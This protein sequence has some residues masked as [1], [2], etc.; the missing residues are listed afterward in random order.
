MDV[1]KAS[2]ARM[3]DYLLGGTDNYESDWAA[4]EELLRIAP[5]TQQIA[6]TNRRFLER[7]VKYI[8][9]T[10]EVDQYIDHGSGLPT[11]NNVHQV[12]QRVSRNARV[13][14]VDNDPI[15]LAHG[16]MMLE[17]NKYTAVINANMLCT[18]QIFDRAKKLKLYRPDRPAAA[19]FVS[20]LHCLRNEEDPWGLVRNVIDRLPSGSYLVLCHLASDD[21]RLREEV[22]ALMRRVTDGKWGRVRSIEQ[23]E[24]FFDGLEIIGDLGDVSRWRP[25]SGLVPLQAEN[26]WIEYGGVGR[27]P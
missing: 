7:A 8:A 22:T 27:V 14:Y 1:T 20:V 5:S 12:A 23:V 10:G 25:G 16:R 21:P 11:Q 4:C 15:V 13:M 3:Y 19:L 17:E 26:E 6:L 24:R 9:D 18:D 2:V